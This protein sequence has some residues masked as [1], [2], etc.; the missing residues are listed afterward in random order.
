MLLR[1]GHMGWKNLFYLRDYLRSSLWLVPFITIP[2]ELAATRI[3]HRLDSWLGWTLRDLGVS[4]AQGMLNAIITATLSF[5]VFAG[6]PTLKFGAFT[7]GGIG[8]ATF[9][10]IILYQHPLSTPGLER[11]GRIMPWGHLAPVARPGGD[12]IISRK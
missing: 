1:A 8:T 12:R 2:I 9:G 10:A 4:G 7:K 5:V 6:D 3:L 11:P